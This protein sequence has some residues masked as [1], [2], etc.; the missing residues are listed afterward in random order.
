MGSKNFC[1]SKIVHHSFFVCTFCIC[2][3]TKMR[4]FFFKADSQILKKV[5]FQFYTYQVPDIIRYP[6][7]TTHFSP[8]PNILWGVVTLILLNK[9]LILQVCIK[10]KSAVLSFVLYHSVHTWTHPTTI[11][12]LLLLRACRRSFSVSCSQGR[13]N[14][15]KGIHFQ[16]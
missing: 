9:Y 3:Y 2:I 15:K 4:R 11:L 16:T 7:S 10:L 13:V 14:K 1:R 5:N 12:L 8:S 6:K